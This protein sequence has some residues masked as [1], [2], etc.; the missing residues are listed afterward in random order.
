MAGFKHPTFRLQGQR[1]NWVRHLCGQRKDYQELIWHTNTSMPVK[2]ILWV[3]VSFDLHVATWKDELELI[4][5]SKKTER[6][7]DSK[8]ER[9]RERERE[10]C[11]DV[12]SFPPLFAFIYLL[13][14]YKNWRWLHHLA[15]KNNT[16]TDRKTETYRDQRDRGRHQRERERER[17]RER[18][19][20]RE[21]EWN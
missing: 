14:S 4:D 5:S 13:G 20:E 2:C 17:D 11:N 1:S 6:Q 9:E 15:A 10:C 16:E 7:T 12:A 18:E 21:R 3:H 8:R 19:R